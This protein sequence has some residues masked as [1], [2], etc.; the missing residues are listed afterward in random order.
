MIETLAQLVAQ[1]APT[2]WV[3]LIQTLGFP[4]VV[5]VAVG[6]VVLSGKIPR[7][8]EIQTLR[9]IIASKD[10]EKERL[11]TQVDSLTKQYESVVI[12]A[13]HDAINSI[14][15]TSRIIEKQTMAALSA[16]EKIKRMDESIKSLERTITHPRR[17]GP[18]WRV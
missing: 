4:T 7:E 11:E 12:P 17:D 5:A 16:E 18:D 9:D 3:S 14:R 2:E 1:A 10:R 13:V 15:D 6:W 8:A